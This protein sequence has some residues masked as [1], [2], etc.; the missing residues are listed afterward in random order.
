MPARDRDATLIEQLTV[1]SIEQHL[2]RCFSGEC[3]R[4][5]A[6]VISQ[7]LDTSDRSGAF[8]TPGSAPLLVAPSGFQVAELQ[9]VGIQEK[10][11]ALN[12]HVAIGQYRIELNEGRNG[13]WTHRMHEHKQSTNA[14]AALHLGSRRPAPRPLRRRWQ[15]HALSVRITHDGGATQ[16]EQADPKAKQ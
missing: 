12:G 9:V 3:S 4:T 6:T 13:A 1:R 2:S 11:R 10:G 16:R 8:T 14:F 15:L 5:S 7:A